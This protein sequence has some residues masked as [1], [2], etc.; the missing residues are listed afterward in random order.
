MT[1][2]IAFILTHSTGLA[3][4]VFLHRDLVIGLGGD[5]DSGLKTDGNVTLPAGEGPFPGVLLIHGSGPADMNE[6]FPPLVTGSDQP[7]RPFQ[8]IAEYLS[9]R[10]FEV[11]RYNKRGIGLNGTVINR[12]IVD[13]TTFQDLEND[14]SEALAALMQQPEVDKG[15]ITVIGHSEGTAIAIRLAINRPEVRKVVLMSALAQNL[16][17][18]LYFQM[19]SRPLRY[20]EEVMDADHDGRLTVQEVEAMDIEGRDLAPL[21]ARG[22]IEKDDYGWQWHPG[23]D[24]SG[25][26]RLN[27][28]DELRPLLIEQF[29]EVTNATRAPGC[30]WLQSHF[31]L[32]SNLDIITRVSAS[33]L[34]LQGQNDTQTPLAQALLLEQMLTRVNHPDHTLITYPGLGHT[35]SP[36]EGWIQPLGPVDGQVLADLYAWLKGPKRLMQGK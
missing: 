28:S 29:E 30:I 31:A 21:Q 24:L 17:E 33:I 6:C 19:V 7:S 23:L 27:I 11:L 5:T 14:S 34:I 4:D 9:S 26:G 8:Q 35:F 16:H 15:D 1:V 3:Q 13:N 12:S 20:A 2:F 18:I 22:L 10:G 32:R 36:A 25:D